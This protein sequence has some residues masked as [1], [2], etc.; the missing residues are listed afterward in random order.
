MSLEGKLEIVGVTDVGRKRSHNEDAIGS[1]LES[2]LVV[3]ADGM[4]GYQAGE[5][6]SA[7][8]VD[9]IL[10]DLRATL[11]DIDPSAVDDETGYSKVTL[12]IKA[13]IEKANDQIYET[14]RSKP[15]CQGMGT[16]VVAAGFYDN[17]LTVAHVGDSRLYRLR[18][19]R[20]EQLTSDH[21]LL[22]E[23][24]DKGFYTPE[25]ARK[26]LNKNLVTRA[27]GIEL[28][29]SPD[30][31]EDFVKA[32]DIY[33]LCSDGLTDLVEDREIALI[34]RSY[35]NNLEEAGRSL[36]QKANECGGKDNISVI[37][38]RTLKAFTDKKTWTSKLFD[39]F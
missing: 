19:G 20:F 4:G 5:V 16:T 24:I 36:V 28:N 39:W 3:L 12:L 10:D 13:A 31:Q 9:T 37:L 21:S 17:R 14:A 6:A 26:S 33:M 18:E 22:Q 8:A 1:D 2:G 15:E 32:G 34:L 7:I 27:M 25:E 30:V 38:A 11:K 23:L 29:V 35:A